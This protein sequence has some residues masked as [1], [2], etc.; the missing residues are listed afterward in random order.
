[1]MFPNGQD[2]IQYILENHKTKV[3]LDDGYVLNVD[4]N[5][6]VDGKIKLLIERGFIDFGYAT[7]ILKENYLTIM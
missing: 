7:M 4:P 2:A 1:M 6:T 3:W 5:L